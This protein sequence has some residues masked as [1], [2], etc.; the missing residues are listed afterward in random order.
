MPY[1]RWK[2]NN[3]I[4]NYSSINRRGLH[5]DSKGV[6]VP[7]TSYSIHRHDSFV[8]LFDPPNDDDYYIENN[9]SY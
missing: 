9:H 3:T 6:Q 5:G 2:R 8:E 4:F 1:K 7:R